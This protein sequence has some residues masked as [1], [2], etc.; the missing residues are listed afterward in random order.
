MCTWG[1]AA[2][3]GRGEK[4]LRWCW[5]SWQSRMLGRGPGEVLAAW[6]CSLLHMQ[7]LLSN[8]AGFCNVIWM[9]RAAK[10]IMPMLSR[11]AAYIE[12]LPRTLPGMPMCWD[13]EQCALLEGTTLAHKLDGFDVAPEPLPDWGPSID[14]PS[15]ANP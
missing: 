8:A 14:L 1:T 13:A 11:H 10:R 4:P 5:R 2:G 6:S 7:L 12:S 3:A 15:Q 9:Y